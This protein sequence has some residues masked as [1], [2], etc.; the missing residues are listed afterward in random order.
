MVDVPG[1]DGE[2]ASIIGELQVTT[3]ASV[4]IRSSERSQRRC[5]IRSRQTSSGELPK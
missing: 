2:E 4:E 1:A 5:S 3:I